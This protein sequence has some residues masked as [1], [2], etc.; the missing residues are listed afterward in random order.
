MIT[1]IRIRPLP[2]SITYRLPVHQLVVGETQPVGGAAVP[3]A[4]PP[5]ALPISP[6][7]IAGSLRLGDR[8]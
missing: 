1:H 3:E 4:A 8:L 5:L 7:S 2:E 6:I